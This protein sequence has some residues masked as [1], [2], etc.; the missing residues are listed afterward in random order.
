MYT[1]P[2]ETLLDATKALDKNLNASLDEFARYTELVVQRFQSSSDALGEVAQL[3]AAQDAH[4]RGKGS[5]G[6]RH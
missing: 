3:L 1:K 2:A 4:D 6:K 5:R